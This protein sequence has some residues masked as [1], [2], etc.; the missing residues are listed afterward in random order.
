MVQ[1]QVY[2]EANN[3]SIN[4]PK[5]TTI[6]CRLINADYIDD[7]ETPN[8][9]H[10]PANKL[11]SFA[12]YKNENGSL[13]PT[14][15]VYNKRTS[16]TGYASITFKE[17]PGQYQ[18][19]M[20][21]GGDEEFSDTK[22][23]IQVIC[24]GT[25]T[26]ARKT[27]TTQK[28]V[29]TKT[30][31]TVKKTT[32]VKKTSTST[33]AKTVQKTTTKK[34]APAKQGALAQAVN[35]ATKLIKSLKNPYYNKYGLSPDN[36]SILAIGKKA[37]SADNPE[38][39]TDFYESEFFNKCPV[40]GKNQLIW[41]YN[42]AGDERKTW[43]KF[44]LVNVNKN[45]NQ[46]GLI[47]CRNCHNSFSVFGNQI[48]GTKKLT[49]TKYSTIRSDKSQAYLL[50]QGKIKFGVE[51]RTQR[52]KQ[53]KDRPRT[54]IGNESNE[55]KQ[56]ALAIVGDS[57]GM[58]AAQKIAAWMGSHI[59]Y[60]LYNGFQRSAETVLRRRSGNCCDQTRL[61][62][63]LMDA[64]GCTDYFTIKYVHVVG[65]KGGHV[66]ARLINKSNVYGNTNWRY[67]DP[68]KANPWGNYVTGWG[69]PPGTQTQ[70][71]AN[72][73]KNGLGF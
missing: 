6:T 28:K 49:K 51:A 52:Y 37:T 15:K 32:T 33:K 24:T 66:F 40:C 9:L 29:A 68:C 41:S 56:Q 55:I 7:T 27:T 45:R 2:I 19:E 26:T 60:S 31:K 14:R 69:S 43:G 72:N 61:M 1:D 54:T 71:S 35:K 21:Y 47:V 16:A 13:T 23:S 48:S 20:S 44:P 50:K 11:I 22:T 59:G 46:K 4:Y 64:A 25:K 42:W 53:F 5:S 57:I 34:T 67:V 65:G 38:Y 70:I 63:Q 10:Y 12:I 36:S 17:D 3:T 39:A 73:L 18:V 30:Q 62:L 58:A 8:K